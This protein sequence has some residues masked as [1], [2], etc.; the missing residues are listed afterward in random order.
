MELS[1]GTYYSRE[2]NEAYMSVSQFKNFCST[3]GRPACEFK[4]MEEL[5]GRWEEETTTPML[6]GSYVDSYFES[7]ESHK[8]F[9][10][11][12]PELF[13]RDGGLKA[14]Y[15]KADEIIKRAER[16]PY[17]MRFL[18]GQKQVIMTGELFGAK[19]KIRMDSYFLNEAIVDLKVVRA[20]HGKEAFE[21]VKD[22]GYTYFPLVFGYDIQGAVYQEIVRQNTGKKLPFYLAVATKQKEPDIEIIQITQNYLDE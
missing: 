13:K 11:E 7:P 4:A 20:A 16:D 6:V 8:R 5:A 12:H 19:W 1:A 14:D 15:V 17:F 9:K 21:W 18:S 2:A 22:Y 10:M 3:E